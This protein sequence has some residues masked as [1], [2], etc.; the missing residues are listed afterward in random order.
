MLLPVGGEVVTALDVLGC[1]CETTAGSD[2]LR[3]VGCG[4]EF[5]ALVSGA[6]VACCGSDLLADI[7]DTPIEV[8]FNRGS[9]NPRRT[10]ILSF[11]GNTFISSFDDALLGSGEA[12]GND[13]FEG[14]G[15]KSL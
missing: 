8:R 1:V 4:N 11:G 14:G 10:L 9:G 7:E 13:L 15:E 2:S 5:N 6:V 3:D 12:D